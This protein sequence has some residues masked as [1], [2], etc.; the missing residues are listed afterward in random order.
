MEPASDGSAG[1]VSPSLLSLGKR[2]CSPACRERFDP[3]PEGWGDDT[4]NQQPAHVEPPPAKKGKRLSVRRNEI[5][6][7][8]TIGDTRWTF[9]SDAQEKAL[10][11]KC[12]PKNTAISTKWAVG[13]FESWRKGRNVNFVNEPE[14]QVPADL[15]EVSDSK[16]LCKWLSLYV[17]E[18]RKKNGSEF[19]P[20]TLYHL[21]TGLLRHMRSKNPT[22]PNFL[23]TSDSR[24]MSLH[25]TMDNV[26]R[27]LRGKGV[28]AESKSTE[29]F[30]KDEEQ[31][32]WTSGVLSTETP[33]GLL[34][35]VFFQNGK[36]FCLRGG[37]EH[38]NLKLSQ[39]KRETDP[40]RYV[41]IEHASKN[42]AGGLAQLRVKN[43]EVPINA[44]PKAGN[45]CHV[46]ILDM[47]FQKLPVEAFERDNFY[48]QPV[49]KVK[50]NQVWFTTTPVGKNT[51]S[52]DLCVEAGVS[53]QKSNH[54]LR[55]TGCTELYQASVPEKV[56]QERTG[57]LSLA[58]LRQYERTSSK[59]QEVVSRILASK[60][61]TTYQQQLSMRQS[62]GAIAMPMT[63]F[64][65]NNCQVSINQ[66]PAQVA[67]STCTALTNITNTGLQS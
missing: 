54:S 63:Q 4:E 61:P 32:L 58:G 57:H 30:T 2:K 28:A 15:L 51:L 39:F 66:V 3:A 50:N 62:H 14:K 1:V 7:A 21:L 22:C 40:H 29:A 64:T 24:F 46:Y 31:Q 23:D 59:Q 13:N 41:Y 17:A 47:Y 36:N 65:F 55:A 56:I 38:R 8:V 43:K 25:N 11:A 34:G 49:G 20:K 42:R 9:V 12:V 67:T 37:E 53:G 18:A 48:L 10:A 26:F 33:K 27:Q 16:L 35:A 6:K 19:P 5:D 52:K 60:E 44:V 45:R